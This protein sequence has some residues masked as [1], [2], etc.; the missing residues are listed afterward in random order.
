MFTEGSLKVHWRFTEGSLKVHWRFTEGSLK[1]H[2]RFTECS[3][4]VHWKF[5]ECW[6]PVEYGLEEI[7][8]RVSQW[9]LGGPEPPQIAAFSPD[10]VV[11]NRL[12]SRCV[13][14]FVVRKGHR[15]LAM[16]VRHLRVKYVRN[17]SGIG[18]GQ[19][20]RPDA[21]RNNVDRPIRPTLADGR[22]MVI[23]L[24]WTSSPGYCWVTRLSVAPNHLPIRACE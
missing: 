2:W 13:P 18:H 8:K 3:L 10:S 23:G 22:R 21:R 20:H 5:T 12:Y 1:V 4:K 16:S 17:Q 19:K 24:L 6:S 11:W 7:N 9:M 14:G 15:K